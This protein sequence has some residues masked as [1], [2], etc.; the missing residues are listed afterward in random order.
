MRVIRGNIRRKEGEERASKRFDPS[1]EF[2][3]ADHPLKVFRGDPTLR[4]QL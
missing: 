1:C 2:K 4:E 3:P